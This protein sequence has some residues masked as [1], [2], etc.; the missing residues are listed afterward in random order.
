MSVT[1]V[2]VIDKGLHTKLVTYVASMV[3]S[4]EYITN[5]F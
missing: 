4:L 2:V 1:N 3:T 5:R